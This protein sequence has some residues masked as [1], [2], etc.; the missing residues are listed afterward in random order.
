VNHSLTR[1]AAVVAMVAV[2][3]S[4]AACGVPT[5]GAP[6]A[7]AKGQAPFDVLNPATSTTVNSSAPVVGVSESIFLVAPNQHL[8]AVSRN[9]ALTAAP[10]NL[11]EIVAALLEGPTAAESSVG[12]Q[13]FLTPGTKVSATVA[14]GIATIN[15]SANP[16]PVGPN[17][18]LAIAQVVFTATAAQLGVTGVAFQIAGQPIGV[19][20]ALGAQVPGPVDRTSYAPQAPG[21]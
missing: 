13:S 20:T 15:F 12:L 17:Q 2:A 16:I 6:T 9:L 8:F 14:G 18:I 4:S 19:P 5:N 3:A 10:A 1:L 21:P 11:A 7:I